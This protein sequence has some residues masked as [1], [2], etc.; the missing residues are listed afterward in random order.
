MSKFVNVLDEAAYAVAC[1]GFRAEFGSVEFDG[2]NGCVDVSGVILDNLGEHD[3][4]DRLR[5]ALG[6]LRDRQVVVWIREDSYGF[7]MRRDLAVCGTPGEL[8]VW[9]EFDAAAEFTASDS[10]DWGV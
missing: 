5:D 8:R 7:V 4:A 3:L 6:E 10:D 9:R 1:H 2:W